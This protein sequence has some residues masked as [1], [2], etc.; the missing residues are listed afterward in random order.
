[1]WAGR[2]R[3]RNINP[4]ASTQAQD[5]VEAGSGTALT[6]HVLPHP[7]DSHTLLRKTRHPL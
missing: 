1:M 7:P 2:L 6:S 3:L 5:R 4:A